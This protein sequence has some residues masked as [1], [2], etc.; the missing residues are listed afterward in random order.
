MPAE[1]VG[2]HNGPPT[3]EIVP[4][5]TLVLLPPKSHQKLIPRT[6]GEYYRSGELSGRETFF[7]DLF[8]FS[9]G[10]EY[11]DCSMKLFNL[12]MDDVF[13]ESKS[14]E[15][16]ARCQSHIV[17]LFEDAGSASFGPLTANLMPRGAI[18][19]LHHDSSPGISTACAQGNEAEIAE[20]PPVKLW[21]IYPH[22][23]IGPLGTYQA[24]R[25]DDTE[26][27]RN[28]LEQMSEGGFWLQRHGES[29][30]MP[31]WVP[32]ST[33]TLR[34]SYL[35]GQQF[36]MPA[37]HWLDREMNSLWAECQSDIDR[38]DNGEPQLRLL[39]N[40]KKVFAVRSPS[41]EEVRAWMEHVLFLKEAFGLCSTL[42][43]QIRQ[44][45][46]SAWAP[47]TASPEN[48]VMCRVLLCS[49]ASGL[50]GSKHTKY[51]LSD[52]WRTLRK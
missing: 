35:V 38:A 51:H 46:I 4:F 10:V 25:D 1:T 14:G 8:D 5:Q 40:M 16:R 18:A 39:E 32:H 17:D 41:E 21:L 29:V 23:Q 45:A 36:Y 15:Y 42:S 19:E 30:Y 50:S 20:R 7:D 48:C 44:H 27:H 34:N 37:G 28:C 47:H 49:E 33:L 11:S 2:E 6:K 3:G 12:P 22:H 52:I 9:T 43:P 24:R 31:P 13:G 26:A